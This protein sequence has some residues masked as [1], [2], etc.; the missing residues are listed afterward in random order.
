MKGPRREAPG[1]PYREIAIRFATAPAGGLQVRVDTPAGDSEWQELAAPLGGAEAERLA[2]Q[3]L[4]AASRRGRGDEPARRLGQALFATLFTRQVLGRYHATLGASRAGAPPLRL[5]FHLGSGSAGEA[6]LHRL[7]WEL[8]CE[9]GH[10]AGRLLA[11]DRHLSVVRHMT[12]ADGVAMPPRP[13]RLRV[14]LAAAEGRPTG[15]REG[16]TE[17]DLGGEIDAIRAACGDGSAVE[18]EGLRPATLEDLI[19][20]LREGGFHVLHLSGHGDLAGD[21]GVVL[22]P[23]AGGRL[24]PW[25]GERLAAQLDGLSPLRL[26][27]LN[28]CRTAEA[29]AGR[30]FAGVAGAFMARGVPAVVAMQAPI[31]DVA[32][33]TFATA[34]YGRLAAGAGLDA[35]ISEGRLAISR[36][37]PQTFE[38]AVPVLF[39]RLPGTHL[40]AAAP[41]DA[42]DADGAEEE[43]AEWSGG[44]GGTG[45][46]AGRAGA[47]GGAS[48]GPG[49]RRPPP[50]STPAAPSRAT[51]RWLLGLLS[52]FVFIVL[53]PA[54]SWL[55]V[56]EPAGGDGPAAATGGSE[57][58]ASDRVPA[59]AEPP[60]EETGPAVPVRPGATDAARP[61]GGE[62]EAGA[63]VPSASPA[64][65][66]TESDDHAATGARAIGALL[67]PPSGGALRRSATPATAAAFCGPTHTLRSGDA[68]EVPE[69]DAAL[70]PRVLEHPGLGAYVT[71][72]LVGRETAPRSTN[73]PDSLDFRPEAPLIVR[74]L[75]FD[76][77][78]GTVRLS[79]RLAD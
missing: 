57:L 53:G 68:V 3:V 59:P 21:D 14:L 73:R 33:A 38:W 32:A 7:P 16:V 15:G 20:R 69:L 19:G 28:A 12:V 61:P 47:G 23:D 41:A 72:S 17:L 77:A 45:G 2:H 75:G 55:T 34:V 46:R 6:A 78:A 56:R 5:R 51:A 36:R 67:T 49:R 58:P 44:E 52:L 30:P 65:V 26:V 74:V 37:R 54:V 39:S 13:P 11:L 50:A 31:T 62:R 71:V 8:L 24:V 18:V 63:G 10:G 35:A 40:F 29:V 76:A 70:V 25:Q 42:P 66:P 4:L 1:G 64:G 43:A 9:P 60:V 48:A 22:L 79:C 27:V